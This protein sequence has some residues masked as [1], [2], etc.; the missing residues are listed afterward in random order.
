MG[1]MAIQASHAA[2]DFQHQYPD[3]ASRWNKESN[4]LIFLSVPNLSILQE[5]ITLFQK[6]NLKYTTFIEPDLNDTLTAICVEPC[7]LSRRLCSSLPL[8]FKKLSQPV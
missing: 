8:M 7:D 5:Y 3:I 6:N 1:Q 4:Y 2:I